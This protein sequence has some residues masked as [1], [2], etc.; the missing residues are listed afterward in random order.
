MSIAFV[1]GGARGIGRAAALSLAEAGHDIVI[2]YLESGVEAEKTVAGIAALGQFA[3][4]IALDVTDSQ[5]VK[6]A[7]IELE[8]NSQSP[9]IVVA[10]AGRTEDNLVDHMTDEQFLIPVT[11][12]LLGTFH[13]F[14]A[15]LPG[16]RRRRWGRLI[17]VTSMA[18]CWGRRGAANYAAS[19]AGIHGLVRSMAQEVGRGG[20]TVNAVA[21]GVIETGGASDLLSRRYKGNLDKVA[22]RRLGQPAEVAAAIRFFASHEA[23][24]ITGAVLPVDGGIAP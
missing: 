24:Y 20:I 12:N 21:P 19:K 18:G 3:K 1:T 8:A 9:A 13:V 22:V 4:A 16:M 6:Q 23:S 5:A 2:T 15:A 14:R 10:T 7:F 17:A 11:V